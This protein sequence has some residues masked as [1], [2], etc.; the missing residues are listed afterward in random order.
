[1]NAA[2]FLIAFGFGNLAML[3]WLAAAIAPLLI[4]LW[5]RHRYRETPWAAMQFLL[6]AVRKNAR[7]VQL[8]HWLLLALRTLLIALAVLAVAEP[9]GGLRSAAVSGPTHTMIVIDSSMSMDYRVDGVS[10]FSAAKALAVSLVR[11][12]GTG[13]RFTIVQLARPARLVVAGAVADLDAIVRRIESL[14]QMHTEADVPAALALVND[15]LQQVKAGEDRPYQLAVFFLT[16]LQRSGWQ[17]GASPPPAAGQPATRTRI[18]EQLEA[19]CQRA[20]VTVV[21]LSAPNAANLA[22]TRLAASEPFY[23]RARESGFEVTV[24]RFGTSGSQRCLI[25]LLVDDEVVSEQSLVVPASGEAT[26]RLSHRFTVSGWHSLAV[27]AEGDPLNVDNTR[28]LAVPVRDD[29]R[30]LCI[31]GREAAARYVA[32]A[33]NP[34]PESLPGIRPVIV[35]EGDLAETPLDD[36]DCV[37][38]CN[39]A[40]LT[41]SESL[42]LAR[43]AGDGGGVVCFLGDRVVPASY[44]ALA[45]SGPLPENDPQGPRG[46]D[47]RSQTNEAQRTTTSLFP[48]RIGKLESASQFGLDPLDYHHPIV[49]PFRGRERAG[50]LTTPVSKYFQLELSPGLPEADAAVATR[51]GEPFLVT[52]PLGR[53]RIV[54]VATDGSLSSVDAASGEPWTLWP[55]WPSFLPLVREMLAYAVGG[56]QQ[57]WQQQVGT[58]LS[59]VVEVPPSSSSASALSSLRITRPNGRDAP[60]AVKFSARGVLWSFDETY[61]SGI[62]ALTGLRGA[63]RPFA[64]NVDTAESDLAT[65]DRQQLPPQIVVRRTIPNSTTVP[66]ELAPAFWSGKLLWTVLLLMLLESTLAWQFGRRAG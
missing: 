31:A 8:Q 45:M 14:T 58:M 42:R 4:H 63:A 64:I 33:L 29:V 2:T 62:Y 56:R 60:A 32:D 12:A 20:V 36:F 22:V 13:D 49:A 52:A 17:N 21:D 44:N 27:R 46:E 5:S 3:G 11:A 66:A 53:G 59:G 57:D 48:A 6:A 37:F 19:L 16:D 54:L 55:T 61:E 51:R 41:A 50:L 24:R 10:R 25:E 30:A 35:S 26:A 39:V 65:I 40:Q 23:L 1:M 7:R 34:N 18:Y 38:L 15:A 43:Y 9:Y 47:G 28:W